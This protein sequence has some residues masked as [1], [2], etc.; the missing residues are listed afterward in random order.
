MH[1]SDELE[2]TTK[3]IDG[4]CSYQGTTIRVLAEVRFLKEWNPTDY[5]LS[6]TQEPKEY[7]KIVRY[8]AEVVVVVG[9]GMRK[10]H[11][12]HRQRHDRNLQKSSVTKDVNCA[13]CVGTAP[14]SPLPSIDK[15][16]RRVKYPISVG[17]VAG[18]VMVLIA[19]LL[20]SSSSL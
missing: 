1:V 20:S 10:R 14:D 9:V 11:H 16:C 15:P 6:T 2:E 7:R 8:S 4:N 12:H 13:S 19:V 5:W 3:T 17:M 18:V